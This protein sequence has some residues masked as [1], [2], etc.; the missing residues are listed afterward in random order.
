M[1]PEGDWTVTIPTN[2]WTFSGALGSAVGFATSGHG[3]NQLGDY[4]E[5]AFQYQAQGAARSGAIRIYIAR[6]LV[7]F[8]L[9]YDGE[10]P[11]A[12]PFPSFAR[13]P[14]I[15]HLSFVGMFAQQDFANI[16]TNGVTAWFDAA[17]N[18][19]VLSPANDFM[20][21]ETSR[22]GSDVMT[23]GISPRIPVIPA[24][25]THDTVLA[26]G[27]GINSTLNAW[28]KALTDLS[29][30]VRPANDGDQLLSRLSYWTDNGATYYYDP[31]G[32]SYVETLKSIR[33]E[34]A[35]KGIRLGSL[36]LDSWWYPKGPDDSWFSRSGIWTYTAAPNLFRSDL[37]GFRS[38]FGTP[39][40]THARWIDSASPY[41]TQY[42][43]S[44]NVSIDPKYW[45]R[46]ALYLKAGGVGTYEQDWL[47]L[48]A[49]T[50][51]NLTAPYAYLDN[52]AASMAKR[53]IT[54]QYCMAEPNHFLQSS[55]Y[56]NVTTI[57]PSQDRFGRDRWTHFFYGSRLAGA[58]GVW[59]FSDVFMSTETDNLLAAT[60]SA[61]PVGI[62]D[63]MGGVSGPNLLRSV[64]SDGVIVKPDLPAAP[65]DSVILAD[66]AGVDVPMQAAAWTDFGGLRVNYIF[67]YSRGGNSLLTINP[68][69][70][71]IA[72]DAWLYDISR[73]EGHLLEANTAWV[74]DLGTETGYYVLQAIG[75]S[76]MVLVGDRDQFV[77][78]GRKRIPA[79]S[80]DGVVDVTV[81]FAV[82]EGMRTLTGFSPRQVLVTPVTGRHSSPMWD[83]S[84]RTFYVNVRP[85][86]G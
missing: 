7:I 84:T 22:N 5:V 27:S 86:P 1:S 28:G 80:D 19:Y 44:G 54:I 24:G 25:L 62:G 41:R 82:G 3:S 70:Y 6:P 55:K 77:T 43:M 4:N 18:T 63:P 45:D 71:G 60:L 67:A 47:S 38:E 26:W 78:M 10:S 17:G 16:S 85:E 81:D 14:Q 11:N 75:K 8:S 50:D 51:F 74:T 72:G 39:L 79:A 59:P 46:T 9:T 2:N 49:H 21:T 65:I 83:S 52:M 20:T 35:E 12:A 30:K 76:G 15:R 31:G 69:E 13:Y 73:R 34:I 68:R 48:E 53:G 40:I 58:L 66:A 33:A 56:S 37:A 42:Q 57:R 61:G 32:A 64:R 36:Q 23:T 29:G